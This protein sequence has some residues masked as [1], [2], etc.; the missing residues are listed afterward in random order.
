MEVESQSEPPPVVCVGNVQSDLG[1]GQG[2]PVRPGHW[3]QSSCLEAHSGPDC[4]TQAS[5]ALLSPSFPIC[6]VGPLG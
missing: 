5:A 6:Q 4:V 1:R 2:G 3:H